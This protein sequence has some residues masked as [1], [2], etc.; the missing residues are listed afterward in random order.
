MMQNA[1]II[2]EEAK[3]QI[4]LKRIL[5]LRDE[6]YSKD[7]TVTDFK[8]DDENCQKLIQTL[9]VKSSL[10]VCEAIIRSALMRQEGRGHIIAQIFRI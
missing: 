1:E 7:S 6:F 4:G 3:L 9:Q 2:R 8:L 10:I 5:S